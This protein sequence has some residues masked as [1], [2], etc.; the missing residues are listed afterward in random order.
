LDVLCNL[1]VNC[2]IYHA[3]VP[4][5]IAFVHELA[6]CGI[7]PDIARFTLIGEFVEGLFTAGSAR[8][9]VLLDTVGRRIISSDDDIVCQIVR[10]PESANRLEFANHDSP[11]DAWFFEDREELRA[12]LRWEEFDFLAEHEKLLGK[13]P[14]QISLETNWNGID[15]DKACKHLLAALRLDS[16]RIVATMSGLAGD[17]GAAC[18]YYFLLSPGALDK[19][20]KNESVFRTAFRTREVLWVVRSHTLTHCW[21]CQGAC[22]GLANDELLPPFCPVGRNED[23]VF[24]A[25]NGLVQDCFMGYV[26]LAV[27]HDAEAGRKCDRSAPFRISSLIIS[28]ISN[29][30]Y[31]QSRDVR[32]VLRAVGA[33]LVYIATLGDRDISDLIFDAVSRSEARTLRVLDSYVKRLPECP[34]YLEQEILVNRQSTLSNLMKARQFVPLELEQSLGT[35]EAWDRTI[36]LI[37]QVGRMLYCWPDMVDA[38]RQLRG[39]DS[40]VCQALVPSCSNVHD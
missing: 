39:R 1:D 27:L 24:G 25:L 5:R 20:S 31:P 37:R 38:A 36:D 7:D 35:R 23:G 30:S 14:A 19:I 32:K 8:N 33:E 29:I 21:L 34:A 16:G 26:P 22:L 28:L 4:E 17:S 6:S 13:R 11:R 2:P 40:R 18:A 3:G 9:T 15:L 10:H 12:N